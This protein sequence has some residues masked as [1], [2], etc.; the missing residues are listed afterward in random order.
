MEEDITIEQEESTSIEESEHECEESCRGRGGCG[1]C[2][3][4]ETTIEK[5]YLI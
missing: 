4:N 5:Y 1:G 2:A 3:E